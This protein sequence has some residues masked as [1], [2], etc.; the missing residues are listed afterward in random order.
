M[1]T[2][3][4][5]QLLYSRVEPAYSSQRKGGFQTVYKTPSLTS[6]DVAAIEARVQSFTPVDASQERY[7]FFQLASG[8]FVI[9]HSCRIESH[10]EITDAEGR[11]GAFIAHCLIFLQSEFTKLEYNPFALINTFSFVQDPAIMVETFGQATGV[12]PSI[13]IP[14]EPSFPVV[15]VH[16]EGKELE[17]FLAFTEAAPTLSQEHQSVLLLG[18]PKESLAALILVFH[19]MRRQTR[20]LCSFDLS[21]DNA[22]V[23]PGDYWV[24][25]R[26]QRQSRFVYTVNANQ[27]RV[28]EQVAQQLPESDLY[29]GWL[30]QALAT[31][32]L[33]AVSTKAP[34][35]QELAITFTNK[36]VPLVENLDPM[37]YAEFAAVHQAYITQ[38]LH[39]AFSQFVR[40]EMATILMHHALDYWPLPSNLQI[41]AQQK[42]DVHKAADLI[43]A[44][45]EEA[46]PQLNDQEWSQLQGLAQHAANPLLLYLAATLRKKTDRKAQ[47]EALAHIDSE[48]FHRL[49]PWLLDP[50]APADL[51]TPSHLNIMLSDERLAQMTNEQMVKLV[52]AVIE[53]G[54]ARQLDTL[55]VY[56]SLVDPNGLSQIEKNLKKLKDPTKQFVHAVQ[57]QR[58]KIGPKQALWKRFLPKSRR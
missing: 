2:V 47:T 25:G 1:N 11:M 55:A 29:L 53:M 19:L 54:S 20:L 30:K 48:T 35:I 7:Q 46:K 13:A 23:K 24:I 57:S 22:T 42:L 31:Q 37:L 10:R 45:I 5:S 36:T 27:H 9:T 52:Q 21:T 56:V 58:E 40:P 41:A 8:A 39:A 14:I 16:W 6:A 17:K 18:E 32:T 38:T 33:D 50:I 51:V 3:T 34:L 15:A 43:L 4:A 28:E 49:L 26:P 12:A 44:W